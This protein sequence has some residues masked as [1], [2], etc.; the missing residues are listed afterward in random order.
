[1]LD[2]ALE[3]MIQQQLV[4]RGIRDQAVI[5]AFRKVDRK[6]FVPE[7][8][9]HQAYLDEVLPIGLGQTISSP[10]VIARVLAGLD[11]GERRGRVLEVGTGSGY[12]TSL[13]SVLADTVYSIEVLPELSARA[14]RALCDG[15]G[16]DNVVFRVG[17]GYRGWSDAAPFDGIAVNCWAP[18]PPPPLVGQLREG[19][20]LVL[21]VPEDRGWRLTVWVKTPDGLEPVEVEPLARSKGF[22]PMDGGARD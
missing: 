9:H 20:R 6:A 11:L 17:D 19:G 4:S 8:L 21:P 12:Q 15:L 22:G 7:Y 10:H 14:R 1:V 2:F 13:L 16:L 3:S 5:R 18:E